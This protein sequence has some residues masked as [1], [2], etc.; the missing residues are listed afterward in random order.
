M[1]EL[2]TK[3]F[4]CDKYLVNAQD[5]KSLK[6]FFIKTKAFMQTTKKDMHS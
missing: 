6:A 1:D 4:E 3:L 5:V 2:C